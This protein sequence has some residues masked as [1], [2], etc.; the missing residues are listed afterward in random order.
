MNIEKLSR[1]RQQ[2]IKNYEKR[3]TALIAAFKAECHN[4]ASSIDPDD[5][6]DWY[7]LTLGWALAKGIKPYAAHEFASFI[8]YFSDLG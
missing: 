1:Q 5:E 4:R 7:S 2:Q 8:R 3:H 6:Q